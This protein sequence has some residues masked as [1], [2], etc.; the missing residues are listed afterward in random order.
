VGREQLQDH[1]QHAAVAVVSQ[2]YDGHDFNVPSKLMNFMAYGL[3]TVAAVRPDSEVARIVAEAGGG[4]VTSGSDPV[5]L[6]RQLAQA[7]SDN[8]ERAQRGNSAWE[9]AQRNF[10]PESIAAQFEQVLATVT[11]RGGSAPDPPAPVPEASHILGNGNGSLAGRT[12]G[13]ELRA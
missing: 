11:E 12:E 9:F 8:A 13:E 6:G 10:T 7:L 4:W 3:P 1:L 5:E 2:Q